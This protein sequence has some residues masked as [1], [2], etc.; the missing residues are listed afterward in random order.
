METC[1][2]YTVKDYAYF[3]SDERRFINKV[4]RLKEQFPEQVRILAE[5][6]NNDGCIYC[7]L[8]VE[9]FKLYPK[10]KVTDEQKEAA[11]VRMKQRIENGEKPITKSA[12]SSQ[13]PLSDTQDG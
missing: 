7:Q 6:E 2:N 1:F 8:P 3:S 4:R 9:W 10:R 5:P 12:K 11:R 13:K